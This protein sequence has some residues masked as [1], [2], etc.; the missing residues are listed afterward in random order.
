MSSDNSGK[1]KPETKQHHKGILIYRHFQLRY[2][3]RSVFE[4]CMMREAL[5]T[6]G[7]TLGTVLTSTEES[8]T[9][10]FGFRYVFGA[11]STE[12]WPFF[13]VS[14]HQ[15]CLGDPG[16]SCDIP[17]CP[18]HLPC[19]VHNLRAW[20]VRPA[21]WVGRGYG[22]ENEKPFIRKNLARNPF[23]AL[24]SPKIILAS[25]VQLDKGWGPGRAKK[26]Q[27]KQRAGEGTVILGNLALLIETICSLAWKCQVSQPRNAFSFLPASCVSLWDFCT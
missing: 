11:G 14:I 12:L 3:P 7:N 19:R 1:G 23:P 10:F 26:G 9:K 22:A 21:L 6:L 27:R 17:K 25:L 13:C 2:T 15:D 16:K 24:V 20:Q 8:E 4:P 5:P 18:P